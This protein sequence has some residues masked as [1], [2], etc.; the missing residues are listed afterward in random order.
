MKPTNRLLHPKLIALFLSLLSW[1][2]GS[3][4][5]A[6]SPQLPAEIA[7]NPEAGRDGWLIVPVQLGSENGETVWMMVDT[8]GGSTELAEAL[9]SKLGNPVGTINIKRWNVV[10]PHKLFAAPKLYLG[11][12]LLQMTGSSIS[13]VDFHDSEAGHPVAGILGIDVLEHYCIQLDFA[14]GKMRFLDSQRA[15]KQT[16]GKAYPIVPLND[17]DHRPALSQNLLGMQGPH[18]LIDSGY[19]PGD[20]WLMT[21]YYR[22]WTNQAVPASGEARWPDGQFDGE[23]YPF[24]SLQEKA[25]ES[26]GIGLGF[27]ARHLVTLDFPG[28]TLY[29]KRQSDGPLLDPLQQSGRMKALEP[30]VRDLLRNNAPAVQQDLL[31][32]QQSH[33]TKLEQTVAQKLAATLDQKPRP[34]PADLPTDITEQPLGDCHPEQAG[35]GWLQPSA[36]RIPLSDEVFSPLLDAGTIHATGL[37]AHSPS[38]Y[39]Y[40]LGGKWTRLRGDAGLHTAFQLSAYGVVFVIKADG[41]EVFRSSAIR[42]ASQAHYDLNVTGVN[43]LELVVEKAQDGNGGNWALWLDPTLFRAAAKN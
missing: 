7:I 25:V 39:V 6:D 21:N 17:R 18:S 23:T 40:Q 31:Q 36:N 34:A 5:K 2:A 38:R 19:L 3:T 15:D 22:Q 35:V 37:F 11:G 9:E 13:T 1:C 8:G 16:W 29:L 20:G 12:A 14:A 4:A 28:H 27:L 32:I 10:T 42:G 24:V 26:D 33:A 41:K 30:M 43:T